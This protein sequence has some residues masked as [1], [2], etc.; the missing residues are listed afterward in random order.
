MVETASAIVI[1]LTGTPSTSNLRSWSAAATSSGM[2][3]LLPR[4]G[5]QVRCRH[6]LFDP[7]V[8]DCEAVLERNPR[9]PAEHLAQAG[10][11]GV[12]SPDTLRAIDVANPHRDARAVSDDAGQLIDTDHPVL[13][14]VQRLRVIGAHQSE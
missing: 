10:V 13:P 1:A 7:R 11:V 3:V 6:L 14:E 5:D 9:L 2:R 4:G 8:G 12:A